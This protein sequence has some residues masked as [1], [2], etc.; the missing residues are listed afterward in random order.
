MS[1]GIIDLSG[2]PQQSGWGEHTG[3]EDDPEK[4][5]N[6]GETS[7][8]AWASAK[9][10]GEGA[11]FVAQG[12]NIRNQL[13]ESA[14]RVEKFFDGEGTIDDLLAQVQSLA[15][16]STSMMEYVETK[17]ALG[18]GDPAWVA[19]TL[20]KAGLEYYLAF[21]QPLQDAVG[22]ILGNPERI[23]VTSLMWTEAKTALETLA[24]HV[25]K[26]VVE[27]VLPEWGGHAGD[28]AATR[29][30]EMQDS[31]VVGAILSGMIA[32]L[33]DLTS[34]FTEGLNN[35]AKSFITDTVADVVSAPDLIKAIFTL[36]IPA[37]IQAGISL[38]IRILKLTLEVV[39]LGIQAARIFLTAA[40]L[41]VTLYLE[42][43]KTVDFLD[44]MAAG[45]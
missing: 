34:G 31:V 2:A 38:N 21:F 23:K 16:L 3:L 37:L 5:G 15:S 17:I 18:T 32:Q 13:S 14:A 6:Q 10:A 24:D 33:M 44:R 43:E 27:G 25:G 8:D 1:D 29:L 41:L 7:G 4:W 30:A 22:L 9:K 42:F 12:I 11:P 35:R 45:C 26:T 28:A 19:S 39:N 20:T 40:T 36:D